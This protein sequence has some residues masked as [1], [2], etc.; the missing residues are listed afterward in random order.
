MSAYD[1]MSTN[2]EDEKRGPNAMVT[3]FACEFVRRNG[4][5]RAKTVLLDGRFIHYK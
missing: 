1:E 5:I 3:A 4:T 2:R